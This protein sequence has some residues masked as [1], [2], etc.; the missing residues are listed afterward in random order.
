MSTDCNA[1]P[2]SELCP[3]FLPVD[4]DYTQYLFSC[5]GMEPI[6]KLLPVGTTTDQIRALAGEY[7]NAN[8][9][10]F[11]YLQPDPRTVS[12]DVHVRRL[13]VES[14][15]Y[16]VAGS[17]IGDQ[18]HP[19]VFTFRVFE[20]VHFENLNMTPYRRER[21]LLASVPESFRHWV[22]N[23]LTSMRVYCNE[24]ADENNLSDVRAHVIAFHRS[25]AL[26]IAYRNRVRGN[27][28]EAARREST[29]QHAERRVITFQEE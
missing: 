11:I 6:A 1:L 23:A 8:D 26:C 5:A 2:T 29:Y 22:S 25:A 15:S 17:A 14:Y 9:R 3:Y 12:V 24:S 16:G 27:T 4:G 21:M 10:N 28:P 20:V 13:G 18:V 7:V 19:G